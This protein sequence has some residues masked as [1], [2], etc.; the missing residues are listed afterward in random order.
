M[1]KNKSKQW[2]ALFAVLLLS[3]TIGLSTAAS[4]ADSSWTGSNWYVKTNS[5]DT[6]DWET[7]R[8][9]NIINAVS[10]NTTIV[11]VTRINS[12]Q[13]QISTSNI[14]GTS[15]ITITAKVVSTGDTV[16]A[17]IPVI[18]NVTG[19]APTVSNTSY[20]TNTI[21]VNQSYTYP[22]TFRKLSDVSSSNPLIAT[23]SSYSI[24]DD[25][26]IVV[27]GVSAGTATISYKY[28]PSAGSYQ[29]S[30]S[31][32][33]TVTTGSSS[34]SQASLYGA[35][36]T[37]TPDITVRAGYAATPA[38]KYYE[39]TS[40][41]I[42]DTSI[43]TA[44]IT[45]SAGDMGFRIKGLKAG[46]T[47][48]SFSYRLV[49]N[50]PIYNA[51]HTLSVTGTASS[52]S[53]SS[54]GTSIS[55]STG[56]SDEIE[57]VSNTSSSADEGISFGGRTRSNVKL[58]KS[59]TMKTGLKLNGE[60]VTPGELLWL[61]PDSDIISVNKTTGVFKAIAKGTATLIAVDLSGTYVRSIEIVVS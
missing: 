50:G 48:F 35:T 7:T 56:S 20:G 15:N 44:E 17:T 2:I 30:G 29:Q 55:S 13:I 23:A 38:T 33:I 53:S 9:G 51:T 1:N 37:K 32:S 54:G 12:N 52:S 43:A 47:T 28:Y 45:G 58:G 21:T 41:K 18:T 40:V 19:S 36:T 3:I 34:G 24:G 31:F 42:A 26:T 6:L 61:T 11:Q 46:D 10:S 25:G 5:T 16:T 59:Y 27:V 14:E 39:I 8:Y 22:Q 60:S 57:N 4:A 49:N